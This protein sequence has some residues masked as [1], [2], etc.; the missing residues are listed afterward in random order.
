VFSTF[1][2]VI[3]GTKQLSGG[4]HPDR[5]RPD[6]ETLLLH[7]LGK[8]KAWLL[9]HWDAEVP[10][11]LVSRFTDLVDRRLR[12]EPIQHIIGE[13]EFYSLPFRVTGDVLIPRPETELL[14]EKVIE[15]AAHLT[16][17][18]I[19][20]VGTG[21]G[22]IAIAL[23]HHLPHAT[24]TAIDISAP[25]LAI[26]RENAKCNGVELRLLQGD[27]LECV[28]SEAFDIVASN[29]PYVAGADRDA[30]SIE[31]RDY[32]PEM[33]LFAGED[34]LAIYS[35]LIPAAFKALG[36]GGLL[37][38]E[39]GYGQSEAVTTLLNAASFQR[40]EIFPDLQGIPRVAF[41]WRP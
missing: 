36:Q 31:V 2:C 8:N 39:C 41:A 33:A 23:A 1:D 14:V 15:Q 25:A 40:I 30:L 28:A 21:S 7:L 3:A 35:R 27:L 18:R 4:P 19:V 5:S 32:E 12:G 29:P 37:A 22:A 17:P 16:R 24:V 26:A 38:L 20:D 13:Q 9:A 10:V 34:G 11:E 6:A